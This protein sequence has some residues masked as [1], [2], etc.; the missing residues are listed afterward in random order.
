MTEPSAGPTLTNDQVVVLYERA[1][2]RAVVA[3]LLVMLLGAALAVLLYFTVEPWWLMV[4]LVV[5]A[6]LA[7]GMVQRLLI[8]RVKCPACGRRVLGRIHSI[9]QARSVTQCLTCKAKLRG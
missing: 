6:I 3:H 7:S 1:L 5:L 4:L 8:L 2:N 9:I